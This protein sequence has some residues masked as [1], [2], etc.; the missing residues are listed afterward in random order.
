L[1]HRNALEKH[2]SFS[3]RV[4]QK[5]FIAPRRIN[6]ALAL[7]LRCCRWA[8]Q[9]PE[10]QVNSLY[11]D[12]VDLDQHERSL[13]GEFAKDKV[14]IRWYGS[15][16]D[17][18]DDSPASEELLEPRAITSLQT[19]TA[20]TWLELKSRRGV[21]STKMRTVVEVPEMA[22]A[23]ERL[24]A[25]IVSAQTLL[26]TMAAF[27][28]LPK[29]RLFPVVVVSYR[30]R[31]FVEPRTGAGISLDSHIRSSTVLPGLGRGERGLELPGAVI[32]LKGQ[33]L[34]L[35][36]CLRPLAEIGCSW[37]R[38]SKYSSSLEAHMSALGTVSRLWPPGTMD[39]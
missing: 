27:G 20:P 12:T 19:K 13:A 36:L 16:H 32:E 8:S 34:D 3:E 15:E 37:T 29:G 35:P 21:T 18:H 24:G 30:R 6:P 14:R 22:L 1:H 4:E 9:F 5:F 2:R 25:G 28:Y 31:R 11:F 39:T 33:T 23:L 17:P 7:L 38:Y 26:Q 10:E